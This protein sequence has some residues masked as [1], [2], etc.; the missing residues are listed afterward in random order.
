MF[1]IAILLVTSMSLREYAHFI[2]HA[3]IDTAQS[4]FDHDLKFH[5]VTEAEPVYKATSDHQRIIEI[6]QILC[7]N[8]SSIQTHLLPEPRA[9]PVCF[10]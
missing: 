10:G 6:I 5:F 3:N 8:N 1:L 7:E 4:S 9:P 2:D